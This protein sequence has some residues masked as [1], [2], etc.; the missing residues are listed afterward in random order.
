MS[1]DLREL[2]LLGFDKFLDTDFASVIRA[3]SKIRNLNLRGCTKVAGQTMQALGECCLDLLSLNVSYT[4]V[5]PLSLSIVIQNCR[6]LQTLKA[7]GVENWVSLKILFEPELI[8]YHSF[9]QTW[10]SA[11]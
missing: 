2:S 4:S 11:S 10:P 6:G 1:G 5:T 3:C 7:A 8:A 9:R